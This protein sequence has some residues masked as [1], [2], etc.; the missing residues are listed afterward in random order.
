MKE[1]LRVLIIEDREDDVLLIVRTLRKGGLE[2]TWQRFQTAEDMQ[3]ALAQND[4]D[5]IISDYKMPRFSAPEALRVARASG[6]DIPFIVVSGTIGEEAAVEMM[7]IGAHDYVMKDNLQRLPEAI[8]REIREAGIRKERKWAEDSL[9]QR[10]RELEILNDLGRSLNKTLT[11]KEVVQSAING[12]V[13]AAQSDLAML[14]QRENNNLVLFG[15]GPETSR[16]LDEEYRRVTHQVGQCLC[17]LAVS[18]GKP[19]FSSDLQSDPRCTWAECKKVG[20]R[21]CVA[22][23][24]HVGDEVIG[25]L[26]LAKA[27]E[28]DFQQQ[29]S[30]LE[31]IASQISTAIH[32][33]LL[34]EKVLHHANML[35]TIFHN[36]PDGIGLI[37]DGIFRW[38]NDQLLI[39]TGYSEN[40]ILGQQENILFLS[41]EEYNLTRKELYDQIQEAGKGATETRWRRKDGQ[42]RDIS[43]GLS[44]INPDDFSQGLVC[45]AQDITE[46]KHLEYQLAMAQKLEAIGILAGGI[47]HDFNNLLTAIIGHSEMMLMDLDEENPMFRRAR[48]ILEAGLHG[49]SLTRQ[50]LAFSRRQIIQ[51]QVVN[52]NEVITEM[53][54]MLRRLIREDIELN[55]LLAPDLGLIKADP[56]QLQQIVMNLVVNSCDAMPAGG[57]ITI[58][59]ANTFLGEQYK[60]QDNDITPGQYVGLYI[61]DTGVGMDQKTQAHIFDPFF[62]TKEIT[63]GTGLG[64][65]TVY[66][67]VKQNRGSIKVDSEIGQGT[68][69]KIYLPQVTDTFPKRKVKSV[70]ISSEIQ[71]KETILVVEDNDSLRSVVVLALKKYGYQVLEAHNGGS[72]L[73][74]CEGH[75]GPIDL[76]VT[77]IVMPGI[78]GNELADKLIKRYPEMKILYI[79]GYTDNCIIRH[80]VMDSSFHFLQKPFKVTQLLLKIREIL[81]IV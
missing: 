65:S 73:I 45:S 40:D 34:H 71:G 57:Q 37:Q 42:I 30:F 16:F 78:S 49:S 70:P 74:V 23:P 15:F 4:W 58:E 13:K 44:P 72:A 39:I 76:M 51:L 1:P 33:A 12:V 8:R 75:Q 50:L 62:T 48:D 60:Q 77:D 68:T 5:I 20:L 80:G 22:L 26:A 9:H 47:A 35:R 52:L 17:G 10:S 41:N 14:F 28:Y 29:E 2:S 59:T 69:F 54:N 3:T 21:S 19:V 79:S 24:L 18:E 38:V 43:L 64:L 31:T 61:A 7:K 11:L 32:N 66:G 53:E 46:R 67:I 81:D 55:I 56:G 63:K 36:A 6:R 27:R 25:V